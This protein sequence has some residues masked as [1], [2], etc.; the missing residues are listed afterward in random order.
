MLLFQ[1]NLSAIKNNGNLPLWT[2]VRPP[3]DKQLVFGHN[4]QCIYPL[5]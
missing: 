3:L 2:A 4:H 5:E 1:N